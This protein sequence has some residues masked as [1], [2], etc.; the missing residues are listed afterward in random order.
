MHL[1]QI[2]TIC[3]KL[4]LLQMYMSAHFYKGSERLLQIFIFIALLYVVQPWHA[5]QFKAMISL[6]T[7]LQLS[8]HILRSMRTLE[9]LMNVLSPGL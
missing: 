7:V 1:L 3:L 4:T 9:I 5:S 2:E 6:H 8:P